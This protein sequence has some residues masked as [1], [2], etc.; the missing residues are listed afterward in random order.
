MLMRLIHR[1]THKTNHAIAVWRRLRTTL[2]RFV[3]I[4][5][6]LYY[7][8]GLGNVCSAYV[9]IRR[10]GCIGG[11]CALCR[12]HSHSSLI[13]CLPSFALF[14]F[15]FLVRNLLAAMLAFCCGCFCWW[16]FF[17][18][19]LHSLSSATIIDRFRFAH[20]FCCMHKRTTTT[21]PPQTKTY[22]WP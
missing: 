17:L 8:P 9:Y 3:P 5:A 10:A 1:D 12:E 6:L 7:C 15:L 14:I 21:P 2:D 22:L 18:K 16:C 19:L 11:H 20:C 13:S 4:Y